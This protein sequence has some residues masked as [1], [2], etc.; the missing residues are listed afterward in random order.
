MRIETFVARSALYRTARV[1]DSGDNSVNETAIT[2]VFTTEAAGRVVDQGVQLFGGQAL[3]AGHP[4]E[5]LYREA[6]S[7]RFVEGASDLLR[8]N[9]AKGKLELGKGR[10]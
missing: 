9:I 10:L 4:L 1:V 2:K 6:R 3:V 5:K 7:L 8:L